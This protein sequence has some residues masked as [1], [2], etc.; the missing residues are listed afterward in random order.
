MNH[1]ILTAKDALDII[2]GYAQ[3]CR[4]NGDSDMRIILNLVRRIKDMINEGKTRD[5][6]LNNFVEG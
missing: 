1:P 4:E 6:I 2:A 3:G 5:E